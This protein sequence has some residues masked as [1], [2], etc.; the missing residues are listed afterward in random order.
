MPP[1][2]ILTIETANVVLDAN[3]ALTHAAIK[4]GPYVALVVSDNG[5]GMDAG[6]Q[7]RLFE[8]FFTTKSQGK[9]TGLGLTTVFGIVKQSGGSIEVY[10]DPGHGTS[11]KVY[12]PR[13][14]RPAAEESVPSVTTQAPG[15]ETILLAEDDEQ[16]RKLVRETLQQ[17]GYAL[18]DAANAADARRIAATHRGTIH[19]LITDLVMPLEGGR[20][21]AGS[22]AARRPP[23]KVLFMSGYTD[24]AVVNNGL[25]NSDAAFIQ[26]PF[27][28]AA[29]SYKVRRTLDGNGETS[30]QA[31]GS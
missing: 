10:S 15:S 11:I 20:E 8:P 2:G 13:L 26:K 4:P 23:I 1:G 21:L 7:A 27:T 29:L 28:P 24:H 30:H 22:L 19:L 16:V 18:L 25:L 14:D 31:C 6:T 12:L 3:Y 9:G 5:A 17:Q